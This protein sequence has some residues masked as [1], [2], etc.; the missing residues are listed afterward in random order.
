MIV[1]SLLDLKNETEI[2]MTAKNLLK[3]FAAA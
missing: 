3:P 2:F 1:Q